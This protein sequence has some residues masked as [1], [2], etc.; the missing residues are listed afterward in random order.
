MHFDPSPGR[1]IVVG[2]GSPDQDQAALRWALAEATRRGL[3]LHLVHAYE[4]R[5]GP[6]WPARLRSVPAGLVAEARGRAEELLA[7]VVAQI[8][9]SHPEPIVLPKAV[10]GP[11]TEVL[12]GESRT[13]ELLVIGARQ[14]A[15]WGSML[16]S[17][18]QGIAERSDCPVV[19]VR[20]VAGSVASR[21]VVGLDL[22]GDSDLLL[23]F[24]FDEAQR[25][26]AVLEAI[27]CWRPE[28]TDSEAVPASSVDDE[29]ATVEGELCGELAP[30]ARK[31]PEIEVVATV[32]G[33]RP[34]PGLIERGSGQELLVLGRPGSHPVRAQ[35]GSVHLAALRQA[36]CPVALV[37]LGQH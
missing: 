7:A 14:R 24:A 30:W 2:L 37:P 6:V 9:A 21:V 32:S 13:A 10:E 1:R 15:S 5:P 22:G 28:L 33:R 35:L 29:A 18:E 34:V 20:D 36:R 4:W 26:G 27:T 16:G 11:V 31:F 12:Q 17:V 23:A 3:P 19:V 8:R 25:R